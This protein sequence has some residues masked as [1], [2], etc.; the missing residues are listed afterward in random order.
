MRISDWSSDVCSSDLSCEAGSS[1]RW[2]DGR[3]QHMTTTTTTADERTA[4]AGT[5]VAWKTRA[6]TLHRAR[7]QSWK[8]VLVPSLGSELHALHVQQQERALM[9]TTH[10]SIYAWR[11]E[12]T[13]LT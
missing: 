9:A 10:G 4:P 3:V 12:T 5:A 2:C 13:V 7:L 11:N 1:S 8:T 6:L